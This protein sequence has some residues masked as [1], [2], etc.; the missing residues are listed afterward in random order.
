MN[1]PK[2][3]STVWPSSGMAHFKNTD[4]DKLNANCHTTLPEPHLSRSGNKHG[5]Y[6]YPAA[7][8][9]KNCGRRR[10]AWNDLFALRGFGAGGITTDL[11]ALGTLG[12]CIGAIHVAAPVPHTAAHIVKPVA[13][14]GKG[15]DRRSSSDSA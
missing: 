9:S 4:N 12:K 8:H 3:R 10:V 1:E 7:C 2:S 11:A 14:R 13:V 5:Y 6:Q 15:T